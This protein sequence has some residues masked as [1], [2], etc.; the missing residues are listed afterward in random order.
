MNEAPV[1]DDDVLAAPDEL[2]EAVAG[3]IASWRRVFAMPQRTD[4]VRGLLLNAARDLF[5]TCKVSKTVY[6]ASAAIVKQAVTDALADLANSVGIPADD[7]QLIFDRAQSGKPPAKPNGRGAIDDP[8]KD[9]PPAKSLE[10]FG[11]ET[12]LQHRI[13]GRLENRQDSRTH[14]EPIALSYFSDLTNAAPKPWLIKNVIARGESSSWIGPPGSGK[15]ASVTDISVALASGADWRGYRNKE[16][17][18]VL[19]FALERA[20]LVKRRLIAHRLRDELPADLPIA[21]SGQVIDLLHRNCV[22]TIL[23]AIKAA[24]DH[25]GCETGLLIF[26][27]YA[28]GI[29]AGHGDES[30]AK[31]QNATLA[32]LRR[33]L[34]KANV[35]IATVGHTGKDESRGERGSNAKLADVDLLVQIGGD[36]IKTATVKK[37]NDQPEGPLTSFRLEPYDFGLDED[38]DPFRTF[39]LAREIILGGATTERPLTDQQRLAIEALAETVLK[40][41]ADLP[42]ADGLPAGIKCVTAEQW[43]AELYR[44]NV[45]DQTAKNPRARFF[46]LRTRLHAKRLIGARDELVWLANQ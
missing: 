23:G 17:A 15:S 42:P 2:P 26:D 40:H 11:I 5:D 37:A 9:T 6:R 33:V 45:L 1:F 39:I 4:D 24:E 7:A 46:E 29:A 27:T 12:E 10:E 28:K 36:T 32:N 16:R 25:T 41:G 14:T 31:D 43:R 30:L 44:R 3:S 8:R 34:D 19:Y 21:I 35:H 18:G 13:S 20:D 22:E 38:G